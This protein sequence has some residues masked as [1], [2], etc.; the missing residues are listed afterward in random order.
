MKKLLCLLLAFSLLGA[1]SCGGNNEDNN[2]SSVPAGTDS[3]ITETSTPTGTSTDSQGGDSEYIV[4]PDVM[5]MTPEEAEQTLKDAGFEVKVREKNFDDVPEGKIA[6]IDLTVGESYERGTKC[7][8]IVSSGK[9]AAAKALEYD[10]SDLVDARTE[11]SQGENS[12]YEPI[13]Y[14]FVKAVWLSQFDMEDVY[15]SGTTQR[16]EAEFTERIKTVFGGLKALGFNTLFVQLRP[17]GDSFYPS[18]YYCPSKYVVGMYGMD[19]AYD[20][21]KI[22]VEEAHALELSIHGWINPLR[23]MEPTAIELVNISYGLRKFEQEHMDD[24]VLKFDG[25]LYLNPGYAEVRQ[26]IIDGAAEIV[27]YYDVDGVHIDD[28]FYPSGM[29]YEYDRAALL[30]QT[31]IS[32]PGLFRRTSV[33][34][35]VSGIYSAVKA[36]NPKVLFGVSP[37]GS[38]SYTRSLY[39]D[40]DTW[41]ANDGYLDYIMPQLYTGLDAGDYSFD[42]R[43]RQWSALIKN[44]NIRLIP[45]MD[46]GNAA[47]GATEEWRNNKDVLMSCIDYA[48]GY[49]NCDGFSLFSSASILSHANGDRVPSTK[50]EIDNLMGS[51]AVFEDTKL[52]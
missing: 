16:S 23:C 25:R 21:L 29:G 22:M 49:G 13:N 42:K 48:N 32:D 41:L 47:E 51:V 33:N 15:R 4:V 19:F 9:T 38:I 11:L 1:V 35:L 2:S 24:Y 52:D 14:E 43:Y 8:I 27:R 36:E 7:F 20:P 46:V 37:A 31:E 34:L 6:E 17:N 5:D 18:Q 50:E 30:A 3:V 40:V 39:A 44:D 12:N 10:R 26:L 28:Y 45:G